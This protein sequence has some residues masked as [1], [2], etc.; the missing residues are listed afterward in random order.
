MDKNSAKKKGIHLLELLLKRKSGFLSGAEM[1]AALGITRAALWKRI[2]ALRGK[3]FV[4]EASK[5][6]GY[7]LV[8][9]PDLSAEEIKTSVKGTLGKEVIFLRRVNSTNDLAMKLAEKGAPEGTVVIA[10][11][12]RKGKGRL[13]RKWHSPPNANIYMS[14]ILKP[15]ILPKD[16]TLL[17]LV[18]AVSCASALKELTGVDVRIKWPNDLVVSDKK[19]GGILLEMRSEPDRILFAVIGIGINVNMKLTDFPADI[20]TFATSI[21]KETRKKHKRTTLVAGILNEMDGKLKILKKTPEVILNEW[22]RLSSTLGRNVKVTS[23]K[24]TFI[25]LA[26]DIDEE[27]RLIL[28]TPDGSVRTISSGDLT[29]LREHTAVQ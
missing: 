1:S 29:V 20:R 22:R 23:G 27:G 5:G 15:N 9:T 7:K 8:S 2:N 17:T 28:K 10:D 13:G 12:Q 11:S 6:K 16:A 3:G 21:F 26:V 14:V 4:I 25:G 19:L 18:S 24:E